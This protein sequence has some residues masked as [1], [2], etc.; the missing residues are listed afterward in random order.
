MRTALPYGV[1]VISPTGCHE[2]GMVVRGVRNAG[3]QLAAKKLIN[4]AIEEVGVLCVI[5]LRRSNVRRIEGAEL[6]I[7]TIARIGAWSLQG[8]IRY[9]SIALQSLSGPSAIFPA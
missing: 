7:L 4:Y 6:T 5:G 9:A 1:E 2:V 3:L 8:N